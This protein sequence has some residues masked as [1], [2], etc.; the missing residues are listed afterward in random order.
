[1]HPGARDQL[2]VFLSD[3]SKGAPAP[4]PGA[5]ETSKQAEWQRHKE[6]DSD[7]QHALTKF[8]GLR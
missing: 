1:M 6:A 5:L 8:I 2:D 4:M 7:M 3:Y